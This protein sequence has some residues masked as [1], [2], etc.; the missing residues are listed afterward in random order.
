MSENPYLAIFPEGIGDALCANVSFSIL[1]KK[2][3]NDI[4]VICSDALLSLF[5]NT[6]N[7]KQ[8]FTYENTDKLKNLHFEWI[9]D[10][11][12]I[13][14]TQDIISQLDYSNSIYRNP[15]NI[16]EIIVNHKSAIKKLNS[17]IFNPE[18]GNC[19]YDHPAW[20]LEAQLIAYVINED[21][22][23]WINNNIQPCLELKE[24]TTSINMNEIHSENIYLFPCGSAEAKRWPEEN[25]VELCQDLKRNSNF[26]I[27]IFLGP[28]ENNTYKKLINLPYVI[29]HNSID[30]FVIAKSLRFCKLAITNDCG[31]MH[32]IA[33]FDVP[34]ISIF[35]P[36]N[37][38]CWFFY[39]SPQKIFIQS[40]EAGRRIKRNGIIH[41]V[42]KK[43]KYW[44]SSEEV[45][46][47][48][49]EML[50]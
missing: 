48:S 5:N 24:E 32:L 16:L 25:W 14:K 39:N 3:S 7:I 15:N 49:K 45:Y 40:D 35:G 10:L 30:L 37:P 29:V 42:N 22:Q 43:W 21:Y 46:D 11:Y 44:V 27:H 8:A 19:N 34:M 28:F 9:I 38:K 13:D 6:L 20:A 26:T 1:K 18:N 41:N 17:Q 47:K 23:N 50:N 4:Y 36:T 12:S 31:P 33:N 2:I